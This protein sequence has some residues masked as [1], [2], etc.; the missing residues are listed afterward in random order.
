M[1]YILSPKRLNLLEECQRCF[2]LDVVKKIKRPSIPV[3]SIVLKMDAVFK[4]YFDK[5]REKNE[6]PLIIKDQVRG[7]L[8]LNMPK[9][10]SHYEGNGIML[11]GKPDEYLVLEDGIVVP[12]DH[13]TTSKP[14]EKVHKAHLLQLS[15]YTYLLHKNGFKT[16]NKAYLA[17]YYLEDCNLH[18]GLN[19]KCSVVEIKTDLKRVNIVINKAKKVLKGGIP[20]KG[21]NCR[22]CLW[23]EFS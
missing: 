22:F 20:E 2:W 17:Y 14:P 10:L 16:T 8:P 15:V 13:K 7:S 4:N 5:Y 21:K 12:L 18:N 6:L 1:V 19:I 11:I 23:K 9:T 3:A